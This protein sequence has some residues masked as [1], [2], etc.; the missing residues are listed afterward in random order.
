[1]ARFTMYVNHMTAAAKA[2]T[3]TTRQ[4]TPTSSSLAFAFMPR[5]AGQ[6]AAMA[7]AR[8]VTIRTPRKRSFSVMVHLVISVTKVPQ[9]VSS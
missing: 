5:A 7:I 9:N 2:T 1:M 4:A 3:N 6:V 8:P